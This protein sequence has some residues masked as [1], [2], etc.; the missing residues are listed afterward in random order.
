MAA[1]YVIWPAA[2][3]I[4]FRF[5][6]SEQRILYNNVVSVCLSPIW[7][8]SYRQPLRDLCQHATPSL[9]R[10]ISV[11]APSK[12]LS[13]QCFSAFRESQVVNIPW[14][15]LFSL[16]QDFQICMQGMVQRVVKVTFYLGGVDCLALP[17]LERSLPT[18]LL[19]SARAVAVRPLHYP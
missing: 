12:E 9:D 14:V 16:R 5:V 8:S 15:D 18:H 1:N 3:F 6:P 19:H 13:C 2:H 17:G 10:I 4:N 7:S 11:R